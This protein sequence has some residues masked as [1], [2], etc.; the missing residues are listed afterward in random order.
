MSPSFAILLVAAGSPLFSVADATTPGVPP[1]SCQCDG[2]GQACELRD[3]TRN[4]TGY[5][6]CDNSTRFKQCE[7]DIQN[8]QVCE[9]LAMGECTSTSVMLMMNNEEC[10]NACS[11]PKPLNEVCPNY[12]DENSWC[13]YYAIQ[14]C[15]EHTA[16]CSKYRPQMN[17][18]EATCDEKAHSGKDQDPSNILDSFLLC[19][20]GNTQKTSVIV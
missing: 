15:V 19:L 16:E 6:L 12:D 3:N 13:N 20:G 4:T 10:Q 7:K 1:V 8:S 2:G 17:A 11:S 18:R 14:Q 9:C 5:Y